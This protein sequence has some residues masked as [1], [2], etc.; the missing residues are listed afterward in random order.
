M[1]LGFIDSV[2]KWFSDH[3]AI[4]I[5]LGGSSFI[6]FFFSLIGISWLVS[7]IPEDYFQS[8]KRNPTIWKTKAPFLRIM[9]LIIKNLIGI[10]LLFGGIMMLVLPGQGLLTMLTGFLFIDY[11]GKFKIEQRIV[12]WPSILNSLNW[13]RSRSNKPPLKV[14]S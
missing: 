4:L 2:F 6:I 9:V 1:E 3:P 13:I 14:D 5:W 8:K 11:P 10:F 7:Q 12:A